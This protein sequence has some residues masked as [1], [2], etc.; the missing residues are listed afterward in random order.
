MLSLLYCLF[1][2]VKKGH[3]ISRA[4]SMLAIHNSPPVILFI[5]AIIYNYAS[6]Q[7]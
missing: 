6:K 1:L 7:S 4:A 5:S 3:I 2:S